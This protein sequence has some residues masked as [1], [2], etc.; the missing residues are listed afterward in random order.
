MA[1]DVADRVRLLASMFVHFSLDSSRYSF[2]RMRSAMA[3]DVESA[4]VW[5][6]EGWQF[7][8]WRVA[9]KRRRKRESRK[10]SSGWR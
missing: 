5:L 10:Y 3:A 1:L 6:G 7:G 2:M 9:R 4:R 8:V